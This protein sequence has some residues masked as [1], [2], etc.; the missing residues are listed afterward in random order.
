MYF[1]G[2]LQNFID[3]HYFS[4]FQPVLSSCLS[5]SFKQSTRKLIVYLRNLLDNNLFLSPSFLGTFFWVSIIF[6][7][8]H[9]QSGCN[10]GIL[11]ILASFYLRFLIKA[12]LTVFLCFIQHLQ[13]PCGDIE[14]NPGPK[15]SS[16]TSCHWDLNGLAAHE[17]LQ[18]Y[19][20]KCI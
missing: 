18:K 6:K 12:D 4:Y 2:Y 8:S 1:P 3:L 10:L 5:C 11:V 13:S 19:C 9:F 17:S 14:E 15:Y 20:F 16:L 7:F